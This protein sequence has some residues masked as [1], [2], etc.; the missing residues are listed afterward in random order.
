M[1][2]TRLA[3]V[4]V[5]FLSGSFTFASKTT[6]CID[7][8]IS[9]NKSRSSVCK[10]NQS[11][12]RKN[13]IHQSKVNTCI[14]NWCSTRETL[15]RKKKRL[16]KTKWK[17]KRLSAHMWLKS[18]QSYKVVVKLWTMLYSFERKQIEIRLRKAV[19]KFCE[20][21]LWEQHRKHY[22]SWTLLWTIDFETVLSLRNINQIFSV[23]I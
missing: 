5:F 21:E 10:K 6:R 18:K 1:L 23:V 15:K 2:S 3:T 4:Y 8:R 20:D 9:Q 12:N 14:V 22:M 7:R 17:H 11:E 16:W 13:R 19:K